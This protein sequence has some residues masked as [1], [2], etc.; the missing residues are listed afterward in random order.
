MP[1]KKKSTPPSEVEITLAHPWTYLANDYAVGDSV[2]VPADTARAL[3]GAGYAQV[4][5]EDRAE[6]AVALGE[7]TLPAGT[8]VEPGPTGVSH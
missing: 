5:P 6:V 4:D 3:I 7:D 1:P 2:K 8:D